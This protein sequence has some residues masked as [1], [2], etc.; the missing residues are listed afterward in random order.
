MMTSWP[1]PRRHPGG[2]RPAGRHLDQARGDGLAPGRWPGRRLAAARPRRALR[3][4]PVW[5]VDR[6]AGRVSRWRDPASRSLRSDRLALWTVPSDGGEPRQSADRAQPACLPTTATGSVA[7]CTTSSAVRTGS[8]SSR[9]CTATASPSRAC[10]TVGSCRCWRRCASP[11]SS[12][13]PRA[14]R[15]TVTGST[16]WRS[17]SCVATTAT[18]GFLPMACGVRHF[19]G[20]HAGR[21]FAEVMRREYKTHR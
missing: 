11:A 6:A 4:L 5:W 14:C 1:S 15:A 19:P 18:T 10:P 12:P 8:V 17:R 20:S 7:T 2:L 16:L 21:T 13:R 9:R 3:R